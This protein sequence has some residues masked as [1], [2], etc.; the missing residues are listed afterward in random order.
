MDAEQFTDTVV[1]QLF[2]RG[3]NCGNIPMLSAHVGSNWERLV[4]TN[5]AA[6]AES[7]LRWPGLVYKPTSPMGEVPSETAGAGDRW[8]AVHEAGHAIVG[9]RADLK[10]WGIRFYGATGITGETGFEEFVWISSNDEGLLRQH[11]RIDV[12]ANLAEMILAVREPDGGYPS[13]FFDSQ[14]PTPGMQIPSDIIGAWKKAHRVVMVRGERIRVLPEEE[15]LWTEGRSIVAEAEAEAEQILK[16]H[17]GRLERLADQ[18]QRG[19]MSGAAVRLL[20]DG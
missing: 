17:L 13:R 11:I 16:S 9:I 5:P 20:L 12:A 2:V 6:F 19:P 4:S 18:L 7:C 8:L 10:L 15:S 1:E 3:F 14:R